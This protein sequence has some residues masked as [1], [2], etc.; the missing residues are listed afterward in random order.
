M[1]KLLYKV[2]H[3]HTHT[4]I[5]ICLLV[6]W[7]FLSVNCEQFIKIHCECVLLNM[8]CVCVWMCQGPKDHTNYVLKTSIKNYCLFTKHKY[9]C[10]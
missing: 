1:F 10:S 8:C 9:L 4:Y 2:L 5:C 7:N 3:S 6:V